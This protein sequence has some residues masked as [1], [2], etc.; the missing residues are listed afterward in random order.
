MEIDLQW[1]KYKIDNGAEYIVTQM[2]FDNSRYFD[3]VARCRAIGINVPIVPA[4]KPIGTKSQ[5]TVLPKVFHVDLP[6]DLVN[7]VAAC[8]DDRKVK[9]VG[10]EWLAMQMNELYAAG[11]PSIHIYSLNAVQSVKRALKLVME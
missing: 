8:D 11:V 4:L 7:A 6:S 1:L 3:F 10:V 9:D 2:F 5:L